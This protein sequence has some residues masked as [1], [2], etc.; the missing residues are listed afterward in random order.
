M[1]KKSRHR[2][3]APRI[4]RTIRNRVVQAIK[5]KR[6]RAK[7]LTMKTTK[8]NPVS[9]NPCQEARKPKCRKSRTS[10]PI[11]MRKRGKQG[12]SC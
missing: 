3:A 11:K 12:C 10:M 7:T 4:S 2:R 9:P 6:S 1:S 8:R 5:S